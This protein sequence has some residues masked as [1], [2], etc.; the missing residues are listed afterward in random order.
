MIDANGG[1]YG[2]LIVAE[3]D[4]ARLPLPLACAVVEQESSFRNVYGHDAVRNPVAKGGPVSRAS[5]L[6]Y[7]AWRDAGLGAQGVGVTQLTWPPYQD[8]ADRLG[9]CWK[10]RNQLRVGFEVLAAAVARHGVRGGLAAYNAGSPASPAGRAYAAKVLEHERRWRAVL[11][12]PPRPEERPDGPRALRRGH[13]SRDVALLQRT[14]NRY[15]AA[16]GAPELLDV[17]GDF[18]PQ[19][20]L[21]LRRVRMVLGLAPTRDAKGR[22]IVTPRDRGIL[23]RPGRRTPEE[24]ERAVTTGRQYERHL[25]ERFRRERE[26]ANGRPK[27][28]RLQLAFDTS[29]LARNTAIHTTVGHHSAGPV[30]RSDREAVELCKRWHHMH[31]F[32]RGW[33]GIGYHVCIARSGTII[34]LRPGWATGA[35]VEGHNTGT[36]HVMFNGDFRTARPSANQIRSYRWFVAHGHEIRGIPHQG[37]RRLGHRDFS[38]HESNACP[39][40]NL[41]P[42][43]K[44]H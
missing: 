22:V 43:V 6:R 4:R 26:Q 3:S 2:A 13:H 23:R 35:G 40:T 28:V 41:H 10:V 44:G 14:L 16:W 24:R 32:E 31:R 9:G 42:Y 15:Y 12:T 36:F 11:T 30:D 37:A 18:G 25:R 29:R 7:R 39:G 20:E 19:T 34:L 27:V 33:A 8:R 1:R 38:G 5:Y 17:D 21:A